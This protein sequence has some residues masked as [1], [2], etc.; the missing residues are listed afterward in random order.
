MTL[1]SV[2][3]ENNMAHLFHESIFLSRPKPLPKH[4]RCIVTLVLN[5]VFSTSS[6]RLRLITLPSNEVNIKSGC[7]TP[8]LLAILALAFISEIS[9]YFF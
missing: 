7:K 6:K 9:C 8:T 4:T 2:D 5:R 3:D 1:I